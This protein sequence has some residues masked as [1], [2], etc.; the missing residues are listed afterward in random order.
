MC[1]WPPKLHNWLAWSTPIDLNPSQ[2][3]SPDDSFFPSVSPLQ[4]LTVLRAHTHST[5]SA[6][7]PVRAYT[8]CRCLSPVWQSTR[9]WSFTQKTHTMSPQIHTLQCFFAD[10]PPGWSVHGWKR[11]LKSPIIV[12]LESTSPFRYSN[13]WWFIYL[14]DLMFMHT[15]THN[16]YSLLNWFFYHCIITFWFWLNIC[17]VLCGYGYFCLLLASVCEE[18]LFL[19]LHFQCLYLWSDILIGSI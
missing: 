14:G 1:L 11:L 9:Q 18:Y 5:L 16:C 19:S 12:V 6:S 13:I 10:F 15:H 8:T 3:Q 17:F 7:Q 2:N 4:Q